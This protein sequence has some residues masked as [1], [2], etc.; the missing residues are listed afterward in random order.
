MKLSSV[1]SAIQAG[2]VATFV[3][4][5]MLLIK[6]AVGAFKEVH[7]AQTLSNILGTPDNIVVGAIAFF[8]IGSLVLSV[9]YAFIRPYIP[10]R[11]D[12]VKGLIYGV[13]VWLGMM[14]VLMPVAGAGIF[15]MRRSFVPVAVDLVL[16]LIYG[17][18]MAA[19]YAY[20]SRESAPET[21]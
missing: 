9:A 14:L 19:V 3:T 2:V 5:V 6:N 17:L 10:V 8:L 18:I 4:S 12:L 20:A 15:A 11:S 16:S 7:I 13:G 1:K 21:K